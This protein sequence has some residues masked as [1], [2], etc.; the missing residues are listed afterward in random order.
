VNVGNGSKVT[1]PS[2]FTVYVPSP[3][4]TSEVWEQFGAASPLPHN[5]SVEVVHDVPVAAE[6]L[7]NGVSVWFTSGALIDVSFAGVPAM[8]STGVS[9]DTAVCPTTSVTR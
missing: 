2:A 7:D 5:L 4:T 6:S 1:E 8:G 3:A 9:V